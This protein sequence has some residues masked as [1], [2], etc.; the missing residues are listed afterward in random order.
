MTKLDC[1]L[2][3]RYAEDDFCHGAIR[4]ALEDAASGAITRVRLEQVLL[5]AAA[6]RGCDIREVFRMAECA[7]TSVP[8]LDWEA[9]KTSLMEAQAARPW[10]EVEDA[11]TV[12]ML[13]RT[14]TALH[15]PHPHAGAAAPLPVCLRS[16]CGVIA[17]LSDFLKP[18]PADDHLLPSAMSIDLAFCCD[19]LFAAAKAHGITKDDLEALC[20]RWLASG[21]GTK[22]VYKGLACESS[23]LVH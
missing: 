8:R 22:T 18:L 13:I 17:T 20:R 15:H 16:P 9:V 4:A 14:M 3:M 2:N 6:G 23:S 12:N 7:P 19:L 1:Y 11:S 21:T 5:D 10:P